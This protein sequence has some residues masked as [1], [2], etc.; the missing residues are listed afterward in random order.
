MNIIINILFDIIIAFSLY[1]IVH[2]IY[3]IF[4]TG[5]N[6]IDSFS[7]EVDNILSI[8]RKKQNYYKFCLR[9][10]VKRCGK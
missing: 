1:V 8:H 10:D 4:H 5:S 2:T 7:Q 3:D 9:W 6:L